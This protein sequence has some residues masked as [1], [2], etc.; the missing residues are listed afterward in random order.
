MAS[1][2]DKVFLGYGM[3][4]EKFEQRKKVS[5]VGGITKEVQIFK[6]G[7]LVS[8]KKKSSGKMSDY[9]AWIDEA[10]KGANQGAGLETEEKWDVLKAEGAKETGWGAGNISK[11]D[12]VDPAT[13]KART[14]DDVYAKLDPKLPGKT[15]PAL[16]SLIQDMAPKYTED[17]YGMGKEK[18]FAKQDYEKDVYGLQK[19]A[20]QAGG[21]MRSAYGGMGGGMRAGIGAAGDIGTQFAQAGQELGKSMY[22]IEKAG[23]EKYES[24]ISRW[25]DPEWFK[26]QGK[27]GGYVK[28]DRSGITN[29][30][31]ET[32]LDVL[33]Q[34][35]DAGGS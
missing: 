19:G 11:D 2:G 5:A 32:F 26:P 13:G 18:E 12:F 6:D 1:W 31:E 8:K 23:E 21:A 25:L 30:S 17:V 27:E 16:K 29:N 34:L 28:R 4:G 3:N 9:T 10:I 15:G 20:R 7:N 22:G 14:L 24:D 33:S 35:P